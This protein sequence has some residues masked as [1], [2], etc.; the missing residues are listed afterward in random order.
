VQSPEVCYAE[1]L[2]ENSGFF[3]NSRRSFSGVANLM[4]QLDQSAPKSGNFW[5][6]QKL[7]IVF[8]QPPD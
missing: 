5:H 4:V 3:M 6:L 8:T 7:S 2:C 1:R